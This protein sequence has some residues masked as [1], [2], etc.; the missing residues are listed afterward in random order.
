MNYD[1]LVDPPVSEKYLTKYLNIVFSPSFVNSCVSL[2]SA[3]GFGVLSVSRFI[4]RT[5]NNFPEFPKNRVFF[6]LDMGLLTNE[7]TCVRDGLTSFLA[8]LKTTQLLSSQEVA[9]INELLEKPKIGLVE[10]GIILRH[11]TEQRGFF[12]T[13]ILEN[14]GSLYLDSHTK[15][16]NALAGLLK[17]NPMKTS[18]I[19][20]ASHEFNEAKISQLQGFTSYFTQNIV[21][22][23]ELSFDYQCAD[24]LFENNSKWADVSFKKDFITLAS[25]LSEG[26]PTVLKHI[27]VS[28]TSNP[29]FASDLI[30]LKTVK[31]QYKLIGEEF[32]NVRYRKLLSTC[33][34]PTQ[35]SL[36]QGDFKEDSYTHKVGLIVNGKPFNPLFA[37]FLTRV[38]LSPQSQVSGEGTRASLIDDLTIKE[39]GIFE[40]LEA[41]VG[42]V[43]SREALAQILWGDNWHEFYSDWALNKQISNLRIKM[44][45]LG[46]QKEVKVLKTEGFMLV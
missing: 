11:I 19:F 31:A 40:L 32:L 16:I 4:L 25:K 12:V 28:A 18:Y 15:E 39:L 5:N 20:L 2:L 10:F 42:L 9:V 26:D 8:Y 7:D 29:S 43:V 24:R 44:R 14:F 30:K 27:A 23:S 46:Y 35:Q 13:L 6:S 3:Q 38:K 41:N 36:L 45:N 1:S 21:W 37:E 22:G 34:Q 33:L 17:I